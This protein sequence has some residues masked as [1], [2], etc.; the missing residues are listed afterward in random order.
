MGKGLNFSLEI[1]L[2]QSNLPENTAKV[3]YREGGVC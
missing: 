2:K 1:K 3:Y